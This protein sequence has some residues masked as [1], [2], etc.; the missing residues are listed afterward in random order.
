MS[1][2]SLI[3]ILDITLF[4]VIYST[5]SVPTYFAHLNLTHSFAGEVQGC[6]NN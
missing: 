4:T 5:P 1:V 2:Y 3:C 6:M